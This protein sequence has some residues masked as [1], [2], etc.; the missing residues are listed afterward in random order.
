ENNEEEEEEEEEVRA[1][2]SAEQTRTVAHDL[3]LHAPKPS[4]PADSAKQRVMAVTRTD[5]AK[6]ASYGIGRPSLEGRTASFDG[7][8]K[9]SS[10]SFSATSDQG[11]PIDDEA[12]IPEIGQRV[13]MNP[14]LG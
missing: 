8:K 7:V 12:G 13:P 4:L 6:A 14:D 11:L 3:K 5:S 9:R 2:S 10:A 1:A